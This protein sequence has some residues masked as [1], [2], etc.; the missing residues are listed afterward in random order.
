MLELI[1]C[2]DRI[3][4]PSDSEP[5]V[6]N[7]VSHYVSEIIDVPEVTNVVLPAVGAE[8]LQVFV[9]AEPANGNHAGA[10]AKNDHRLIFLENL[11]EEWHQVETEVDEEEPL[12]PPLGVLP[13]I[14]NQ[15][16]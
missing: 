4:R 10:V 3:V 7:S 8:V 11:E 9:E 6:Q 5:E 14:V 13:L 12:L 2:D 1:E 16:L 15:V